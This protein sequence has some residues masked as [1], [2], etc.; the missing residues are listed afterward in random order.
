MIIPSQKHLFDI[1]DTH[2]YLNT[3]Y[4]S[5][6]MHSV[7][8]AMVEGTLLKRHPWSYRSVDFFTY[9]EK[10]R[11]L[12]AQIYGTNP[13]E[14]A[15][16]PSASYGL[17]VAANALPLKAGQNIIVMQDQFPSNIYTWRDKARKVGGHIH[18]LPVPED[19][20]WTRD[21]LAA[22]DKDTAI[23]ALSQTHWASGATLDLV[24]IRKALDAVGT[25]LVLDLTQSLGVQPF[26]VKTIRPDF[27]VA[28]TYKWLMGPYGLGFLY[29]DPR[30]HDASPLEHNWINREGS[31]D[32]T[33]LTDYQDGFQSGAKKF[34]MGGR[35]N[36]GQLMGV[37]AA[38]TQL[39]DWGVDDISET[40]GAKTSYIAKTLSALGLN[41]LPRAL[42]AP[43]YLG[44][45]FQ[46]GVPPGLSEALAQQNIF[47]SVR[48]R[49]VRVTP[50]LYSS[51]ADIERFI[52]AISNFEL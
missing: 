21:I 33:K 52:T 42:R 37:S 39:L 28:A 44:L 16:V 6:L 15:I 25:A 45:M 32:F 24:K 40:L 43:H 36:P 11:G 5:P 41:V 38:L 19:H 46:D 9:A 18:T 1:P 23:A 7:S 12:A 47:V 20:D 26:D 8:E 30:W 3:A 49:A 17:Q 10:V 22:I 50:H 27:A 4:M 14:I 35:S 48:G 13:D 2:A 51:D 34:D 31:E 29:I